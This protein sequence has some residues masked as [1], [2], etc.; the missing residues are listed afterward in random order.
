MYYYQRPDVNEQSREYHTREPLDT[1][2]H[3]IDYPRVL[4]HTHHPS[5]SIQ[6]SS[7]LSLLPGLFFSSRSSCCSSGPAKIINHRFSYYELI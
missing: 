5:F 6:P 1:S 4:Q 7:A 3:L 2:H